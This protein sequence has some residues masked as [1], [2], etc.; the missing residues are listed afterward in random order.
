MR[1]RG[2]YQRVHMNQTNKTAHNKTEQQN[3]LNLEIQVTSSPHYEHAQH[4]CSNTADVKLI[5][6]QK[7]QVIRVCEHI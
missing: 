6:S 3:D 4:A 7:H 1:K 2:S 5:Y